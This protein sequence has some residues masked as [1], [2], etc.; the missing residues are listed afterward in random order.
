MKKNQN[1][2]RGKSIK[3]GIKEFDKIHYKMYN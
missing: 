2:S 1:V 3:F